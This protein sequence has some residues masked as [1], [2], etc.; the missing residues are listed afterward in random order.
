[1]ATDFLSPC[2]IPCH[3]PI[4]NLPQQCKS[5]I[6]AFSRPSL[7]S[8]VCQQIITTYRQAEALVS[9]LITHL[10]NDLV[11]HSFINHTLLHTTTIPTY[12]ASPFAKVAPYVYREW[13]SDTMFELSPYRAWESI[14]PHEKDV[15]SVWLMVC[16]LF[17]SEWERLVSLYE[18]DENLMRG[19]FGVLLQCKMIKRD[20]EIVIQMVIQ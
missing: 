8:V 16:M 12:W 5:L 2:V 1:M 10:C 7:P 18:K 6:R 19:Y 20:G 11:E 13:I 17:P 3:H 4:Q 15:L 14:S 9:W